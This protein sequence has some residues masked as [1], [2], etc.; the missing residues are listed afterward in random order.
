[1]TASRSRRRAAMPTRTLPLLN[2]QCRASATEQEG[3][4]LTLM[5]TGLWIVW[6]TVL[7]GLCYLL[8]RRRARCA[9]RAE[10]CP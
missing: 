1:V 6:A 10:G 5:A 2:P 4:R 3:L 9:L 8:L 7:W